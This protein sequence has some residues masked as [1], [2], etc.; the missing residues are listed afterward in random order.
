MGGLL[1]LVPVISGLE[2]PCTL[3]PENWDKSVRI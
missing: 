3:A 1:V 2:E